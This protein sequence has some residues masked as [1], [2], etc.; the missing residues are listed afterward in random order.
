MDES[1]SSSAETDYTADPAPSQDTGDEDADDGAPQDAASAAETAEADGV[2]ALADGPVKIGATCYATLAEAVAAASAGATVEVLEDMQLSATISVGKNLTIAAGADG[3][4][5]SRA[6]GFTGALFTLTAGTL[7]VGQTSGNTLVLDGGA[8]WL[9]EQLKVDKNGDPILNAQSEEETEI[10]AAESPAV[11]G[12]YDGNT[13]S[14][15][16]LISVTKGTLHVQATAT[17]QNNHSSADGAAVATT[18]GGNANIHLY[19]KFINNATDGNGGAVYLYGGGVING[20]TGTFTGNAAANNGG[21]LWLD[22]QTALTGGH[23]HGKPRPE[24]RRAVC[25]RYI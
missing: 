16:A 11:E 15:A 22:G 21:A 23:V 2:Q 6:P 7:T 3:V 9:V 20:L 13:A 14:A 17:L 8:E 19:G 4:T 5:I 12:A 24:R 25:C 18:A 10:V 1:A